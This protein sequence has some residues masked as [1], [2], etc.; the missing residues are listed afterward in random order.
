MQHEQLVVH[1]ERHFLVQTLL[2]RADDCENI[3]CTY[4][5]DEVAT[6]C[7]RSR[8]FTLTDDAESPADDNGRLHD[9]RQESLSTTMMIHSGLL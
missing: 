6:L 8:L 3:T 4:N 9:S 2:P 1:C 7:C 5:T